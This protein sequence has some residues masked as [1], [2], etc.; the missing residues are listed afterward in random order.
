MHRGLV[1]VAALTAALLALPAATLAKSPGGACAG[2]NSGFVRVDREAWWYDWTVPGFEEAGIDVYDGSEFS[3][4]FEEFAVAFGFESAQ[5]LMG[6]VLGEQWDGIDLNENDYV[7]I[8]D[9]PNTPGT[10]AYVFVGTDDS[11][12]G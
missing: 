4:E 12:P 3:E 7:C 8:K 10:P 9:V 2:G 5:A 6:W 1:L 11:R